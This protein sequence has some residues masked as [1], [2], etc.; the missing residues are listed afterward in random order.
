M[1]LG[2]AGTLCCCRGGPWP[3]MKNNATPVARKTATSAIVNTHHI[4]IGLAC[5]SAG[6]LIA[7]GNLLGRQGLV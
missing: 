3:G 4:V 2:T 5:D 7:H 1:D 6:E